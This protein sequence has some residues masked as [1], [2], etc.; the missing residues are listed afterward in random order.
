MTGNSDIRRSRG[1]LA[2]KCPDCRQLG[3]FSHFQSNAENVTIVLVNGSPQNALTAAVERLYE[4]FGAYNVP[5]SSSFCRHCVTKDEVAALRNKPLR[6]LHEGDVSRYWWKA[7]S[8]WGTVE[9]F[10]HFL[11]R[12]LEILVLEKVRDNPEILM[13]KL[14]YGGLNEWPEVEREA[15]NSFCRALWQ[16][17]LVH[18]PLQES[19]PSFAHID[20][21]LCSIAQ[22]VDDLSPLLDF[23]EHDSSPAAM[24]HLLDFAD[25]NATDIREAGKLSNTFWDERRTQ[26]RQVKDWFVSHDFCIA[27]GVASPTTTHEELRADLARG[28]VKRRSQLIAGE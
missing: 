20:D 28:I 6:E 25:E 9:E 2:A 23:W 4:V 17:A 18:H 27:F 15:I 21:C 14:R 13:R 22:V 3:S 26:M 11:P 10:K 24:Q 16:R 8:T 7:I 12:L 5:R 19:F 1:S